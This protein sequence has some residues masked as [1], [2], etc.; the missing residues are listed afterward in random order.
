MAEVCVCKHA[1]SRGVWGP[2]IFFFWNFLFFFVAKF[3]A[4][5]CH[6]KYRSSNVLIA[7]WYL[8]WKVFRK[9]QLLPTKYLCDL[10]FVYEHLILRCSKA[11][12]C[13]YIW[14]SVNYTGFRLWSWY[15]VSLLAIKRNLIMTFLV[16][17]FFQMKRKTA[18]GKIAK[19]GAV[20]PS[21]RLSTLLG[22]SNLTEW[23]LKFQG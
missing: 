8:Q 16:T 15:L 13:M 5:F 2:E 7:S 18:I 21:A 12:L 4:S 17:P 11:R 22:W 6:Q 3:S 20:S 10:V 14:S 19:T 23:L 9:E 1:A